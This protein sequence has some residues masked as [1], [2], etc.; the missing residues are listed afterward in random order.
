MSI[1]ASF[2][3]KVAVMV[4]VLALL[5]VIAIGVL[6]GASCTAVDDYGNCV[7]WTGPTTSLSDLVGGSGG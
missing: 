3:K 7:G 1:V 6:A 5:T 2:Q 4:A